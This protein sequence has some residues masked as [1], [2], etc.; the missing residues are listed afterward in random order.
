MSLQ[1]VISR[2]AP[3]A[4]QAWALLFPF[5]LLIQALLCATT[6]F[7]FSSELKQLAQLQNTNSQ[8]S[9]A[10]L[11]KEYVGAMTGN[12]NSSGDT[13]EVDILCLQFKWQLQQLI[14]KE[15]LTVHEDSSTRQGERENKLSGATERFNQSAIQRAGAHLTGSRQISPI[16]S[17]DSL[18]GRDSSWKINYWE[19]SR[20]GY[21]FLYNMNF[22]D[23]ELIIS[24]PGYYY[25][26]SQTYFRFQELE[27]SSVSTWSEERK[28]QPRQLVQYIYK[29]TSY[30]EP[31]LL[32]KS[33]KTSCWSKDSEYELYSMYQGGVFELREN[34]R[35]FVSV[36]NGKLIDLDREASFFGAF[37]IG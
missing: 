31:I 32:L 15:L 4:C 2:E 20:K 21:S 9:L 33:V 28:K 7:Y 14:K 35:I 18:L 29:V 16:F 36:S 13:E 8:S 22:L 1:A 24:Q 6:Y 34:E 11:T 25:I 3:R 26:Y 19:S 17:R 23:G 30:P 27:G 37:L 12:R 5:S 10:C